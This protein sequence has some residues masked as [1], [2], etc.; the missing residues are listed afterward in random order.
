LFTIKVSNDAQRTVSCGVLRSDVESHAL[1]FE[2]NVETRI[3]G[4]R[5]DVRQLATI[6]Q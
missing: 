4:L 1:G 3:G 2:F 6:N 5:R